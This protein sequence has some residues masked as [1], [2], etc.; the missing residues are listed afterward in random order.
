MTQVTIDEKSY[1]LESLT[2]GARQQL[3]MLQA[4]DQEIQRLNIK[5]A[6]A[7]TARVAYANALNAELAQIK[8]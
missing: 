3:A 6:I 2:E 8:H 7:Q 4:T 1:E 5:L